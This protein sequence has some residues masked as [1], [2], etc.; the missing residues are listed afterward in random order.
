MRVAGNSYEYKVWKMDSQ[1]QSVFL[2]S[3]PSLA[4]RFQPLSR[5][6][7][8]LF[9]R[10]WKRK[11]T[12]WLAVYFDILIIKHFRWRKF[13]VAPL[14]SQ[15]Y[16]PFLKKYFEASQCLTKSRYLEVKPSKCKIYS[17]AFL[18]KKW[19]SNEF[20]SR[21]CLVY[22]KELNA[23]FTSFLWKVVSIVQF[24][25]NFCSLFWI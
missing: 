21:E 12:H 18:R 6:F 20:E 25:F 23:L 4:L 24:K 9:A 5:P 22:Q 19:I 8:W 3:L 17:L 7:V 14:F 10:T 2:A 15:F 11:N 1:R 13:S 16:C